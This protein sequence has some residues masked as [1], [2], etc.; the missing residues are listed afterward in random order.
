[1]AAA[2]R[3]V[4]WHR[5]GAWFKDASNEVAL[6]AKLLLILLAAV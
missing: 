2:H 3:A 4:P 6:F 5:V 1:M